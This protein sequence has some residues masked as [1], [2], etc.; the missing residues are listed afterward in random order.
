MEAVWSAMTTGKVEVTSDATIVASETCKLWQVEMKSQELGIIKEV[1]DELYKIK[2]EQRELG[3][4]IGV[5]LVECIGTQCEGRIDLPQE[6]G[7]TMCSLEA[8]RDEV[9]PVRPYEVEPLHGAKEHMPSLGGIETTGYFGLT[10]AP[11]MIVPECVLEGKCRANGQEC[12]SAC[13][14]MGHG[15]TQTGDVGCVM[16][17]VI[18]ETA[19]ASRDSRA[20][21]VPCFASGPSAHICAIGSRR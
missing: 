14:K 15:T 13:V 1:N 21:S 2:E 7:E 4:N 18:S 20:R 5:E 9:S 16:D 6:Q 8:D 10:Q 3:G 17:G 11:S 19:P 12:V